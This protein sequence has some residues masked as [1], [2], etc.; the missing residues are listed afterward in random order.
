MLRSALAQFEKAPPI[1][2][3]TLTDLHDAVPYDASARDGMPSTEKRVGI[4]SQVVKPWTAQQ[5]G[6][7]ALL[8]LAVLFLVWLWQEA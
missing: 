4:G 2:P 7:A 6:Q 3:E 8:G 5:I 1:T